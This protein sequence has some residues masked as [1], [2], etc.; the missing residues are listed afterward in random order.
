MKNQLQNQEKKLGIASLLQKGE[1]SKG[2]FL[3]EE[4]EYDGKQD[5]D[6]SKSI[7]YQLEVKK[8]YLDPDLTLVKFSSI[9]GTN[10]TYLSNTVNR[11]FGVNLK[12]LVNRYRVNHA[13]RLME[14]WDSAL[15]IGELI[16]A[17]GFSSRSIFYSAF[18]REVG[19][20]PTRYRSRLERKTNES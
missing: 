9:V 5:G 18:R 7:I 13:K 1:D 6:I 10:T 15:D 12:T 14:V 16:R 11:R 19:M 4:L 17:S 2:D 3:K 20:T 8:I